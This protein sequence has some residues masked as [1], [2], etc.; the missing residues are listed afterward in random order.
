VTEVVPTF[1]K[2]VLPYIEHTSLKWRG[3]SVHRFDDN[4]LMTEEHVMDGGVEVLE[5]QRRANQ[6]A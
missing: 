5:M 2:R 4:G 1:V 3:M 6:E